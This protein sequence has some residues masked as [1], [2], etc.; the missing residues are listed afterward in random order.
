MRR[1]GDPSE[2]ADAVTY[3]ASPRASFVTGTLM[4]IDGGYLA[5]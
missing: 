3:L 2:A 5:T 1:A 4:P